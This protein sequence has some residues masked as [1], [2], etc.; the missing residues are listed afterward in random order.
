MEVKKD[1]IN[2]VKKTMN[3]SEWI[4][5]TG[6]YMFLSF[7][8]NPVKKV[9]FLHRALQPHLTI[10]HK[11]SHRQIIGWL[12]FPFQKTDPVRV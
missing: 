7:K 8:K 4:P 9:V 6:K 11:K 1:T 12:F 5:A 2:A 3:G 10:N